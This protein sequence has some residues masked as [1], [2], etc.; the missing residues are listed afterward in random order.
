MWLWCRW[1][2]AALIQPL[3]WELLYASG[4]AQ[5]SK[6]KKK[7]RSRAPRVAQWIK[8]PVLSLLWYRSLLWHGFD[9]WPG[10]FHLWWAQPKKKKEKEEYL[11]NISGERNLAISMTL[12]RDGQE[13]DMARV[14]KSCKEE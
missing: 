8:D 4:L 5:K 9:P 11:R 10:N 7:K 3:A 13:T 12:G 1:A 14:A 2:V 6:K